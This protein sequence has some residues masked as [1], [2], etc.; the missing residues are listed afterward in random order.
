[1][2][3]R[4]SWHW[5]PARLFAMEAELP[6]LHRRFRVGAT[7]MLVMVGMNAMLGLMARAF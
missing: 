1:L 4:V 3:W 6:A 7:A 2:F 5:W